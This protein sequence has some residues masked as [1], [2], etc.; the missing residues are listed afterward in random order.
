MVSTATYIFVEMHTYDYT[1]RTCSLMIVLILQYLKLTRV[2]SLTDAD[3]E[4]H[5]IVGVENKVYDNTQ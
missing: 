1:I 3:F 5:Q 4:L 2:I